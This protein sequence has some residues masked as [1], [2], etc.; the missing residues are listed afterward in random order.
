M[1]KVIEYV[2]FFFFYSLIGWISEEIYCYIKDKRW[3]KRGF[4]FGPLCPIYGT[5]ALSMLLALTWC[6]RWP[7]VVFFLGVLVCDVV[8]YFT[9]FAMEKLFDKKWWDYSKKKYNLNGRI[10][11]EHSCYWGIF[12][13]ALIYL[14]HPFGAQKLA[15]I[16]PYNVKLWI[17]IIVLSIFLVDLLITVKVTRKA[18]KEKEKLKK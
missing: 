14:I 3:T 7:V 6:R 17:F 9:S 8:E 16:M 13:V 4:L 11:L 12:S 18:K 10:C 5:G 2:L 1:E 15:Q